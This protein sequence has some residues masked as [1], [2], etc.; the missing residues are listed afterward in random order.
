MS[1][2]TIENMSHSFGDRVIFKN[3]SFRL[4][5]GERIGLVGANGEGKS[6]FMNIITNKIMADEGKI[7]WSNKVSVGYMDQH[8]ELK[9]GKSIRDVLQEAFQCLFDMETEMKNLYDKME[10]MNEREMNKSLERAAN[11]QDTLENNGF[12]SIDSKIEAVAMGLG[13]R[14]IGLDKD[15]ADLSGGERTKVLLAKLLLEAPDVLLLDEPTNYLD[16]EHIDWLERYLQSYEKAFILISHNILFLNNVVNII[17][18]IENKSLTRYIGNYESF[19]KAY[20][21]NKNQLNIAYKRQ[22]KEIA[23]IEDFIKKNK[24]RAS[25]AGMARSRQKKLDKIQRIEISKKNPKPQFEFKS[26]KASGHMI[27]ETRDLVIGYNR[28][29]SI[30]LNIKMTRGQK[31]ALVG[32]NGIG[33]S[34]LLKSL[35]GLIKPLDG[36]VK[37]GDYQ[38]IGYF[39]QEIKEL[40]TNSVIDEVWYEL[41]GYT[42]FEIRSALAKCGLTDKHIESNVCTL[43]G[44]EQAKVRLCK[45]INKPTNILILDEPTDHLDVDAKYELK[46][47]LKKYRGSILL[48]CHEP[49]FYKEVVTDVWDCGKWTT[50][51]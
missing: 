36:K 34:T 44:G 38:E 30:P 5:R 50:I 51:S 1:I 22:Q 39:E 31:I 42:K 27:F 13:L 49:E 29:L 46:R 40:N 32:S 48:V 23:R 9:E 45:L 24:A 7:D 26:A 28:P 41:S 3:A 25:T 21:I 20:E 2:L 47:A 14:N 43:S 33:K 17:Y 15:V 18:H 12:Y 16:E 37:V 6:T 10:L 19:I 4:L 8:T 35:M 11:I